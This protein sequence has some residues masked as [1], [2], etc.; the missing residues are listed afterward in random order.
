MTTGVQIAL[1]QDERKL[2]D[3]NGAQAQS[4]DRRRMS[5][6]TCESVGAGAMKRQD[7]T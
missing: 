4:V 3:A 6:T 7:K 5:T 2:R 1:V